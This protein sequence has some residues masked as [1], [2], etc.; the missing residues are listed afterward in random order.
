MFGGRVAGH[1]RLVVRLSLNGEIMTNTLLDSIIK[2]ELIDIVGDDDVTVREAERIAYGTD[3]YLVPQIWM[4]RGKLPSIPDWIVFPESAD[5]VSRILKLAARHR[6]PVIPYGGGTGSQGGAVPLY[7]GIVIDLKKM[8]K[9][10]QIDEQSMTVTAQAGINGQRLEWA[11]NKHGLT[12]AHY[13]ASEYGATLG[14]Y[15]AARGRTFDEYGKAEDMV[16][17]LEAVLPSGEKI[18]TLPVPNH[19]CGPEP[20]PDLCGIRG[21]LESSPK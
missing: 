3:Y 19:A 5:E 10:I 18:S 1:G 13:P 8:D 12:L 7:G 6:V 2:N 4:D 20:A 21:T 15:V 17:S 14:G 16:L 9:I 11:I